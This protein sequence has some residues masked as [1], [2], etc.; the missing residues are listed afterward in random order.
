MAIC[1]GNTLKSRSH[2]HKNT[3]SIMF[4]IKNRAKSNAQPRDG[5]QTFANPN[6]PTQENIIAGL[7]FQR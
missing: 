7:P 6:S 5:P 2:V 4:I 1:H 3:D